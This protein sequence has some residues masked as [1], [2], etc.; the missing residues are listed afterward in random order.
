MD[1]AEDDASDDDLA[2]QTDEEDSECI[3]ESNQGP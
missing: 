2:W 1:E 3:A